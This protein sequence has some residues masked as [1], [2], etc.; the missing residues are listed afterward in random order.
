ML[1]NEFAI[2][3]T[4]GVTRSSAVSAGLEPALAITL[5]RVATL[6]FGLDFNLA[7]N[8]AFNLAFDWFALIR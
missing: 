1:L 2:G 5:E 8:L 3:A 7:L 6:A 4:V